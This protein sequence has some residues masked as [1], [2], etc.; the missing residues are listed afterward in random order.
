VKKS[1]LIEILNSLPGNPDVMLWNGLVGDWMDIG[2][3]SP[4]DL[5]KM[6]FE[7]YME[8]VRLETCSD[9]RDWTY[10][11]NETERDELRALWLRFAWES[12]PYV[13]ME[14]IAQKRYQMKKIFFISAK[15]RGETHHDRLGEISY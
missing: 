4:G 7:H 2:D 10:Q 9:L 12:N 3:I 14:D 11:L 8:M 5:V 15:L 1:K 13:T 6:T